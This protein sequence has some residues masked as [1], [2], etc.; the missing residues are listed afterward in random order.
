MNDFKNIAK[1]RELIFLFDAKDC[2]PNGE[3]DTHASGP[4]IDRETGRAI[5]TDLRIKRFVREYFLKTSNSK[6][7]N[8]LVKRDFIYN[9]QNEVKHF[10]DVFID[11]L[12]FDEETI[13]NL[14]EKQIYDSIAESF[15]DHRLFGHLFEISNNL[16]GITGP[17]QFETTF[18]LNKPYIIPITITSALSS[19]STKGA[20]AMGQYHILNYAIFPVHGIVK[21]SLARISKATE[22]DIGR[23]FDGLWDGLKTLNTRSKIGQTP[24][25]LLSLVMKKPGYQIPRFR[26]IFDDY[27]VNEKLEDIQDVLF[28][29][30]QFKLLLGKFGNKIEYIEYREDPVL[31][32]VIDK[33]EIQSITEISDLIK[34]TPPFIEV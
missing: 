14:N 7:E 28:D 1:S 10:K 33:T 29:L 30:E 4:R 9:K 31:N 26:S 23:L 6:N 17:V 22:S 11:D 24:R 34:N 25:L 18:S 32:Y 13:K 8:I 3:R 15:I 21:S 5:V 12:P 20:G 16:Y 27:R 19:E 2:N